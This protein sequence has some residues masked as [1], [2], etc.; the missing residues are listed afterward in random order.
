M[1]S[2]KFEIVGHTDNLGSRAYNLELSAERA[3]SV[4]SY[5]AAKGIDPGAISADGAGP[6]RPVASNATA[7]GRA[8][9]R[10]IEFRVIN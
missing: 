3:A 8:R 1:T 6:D 7:E 10:R 4:K 2:Q 5:L 9:N